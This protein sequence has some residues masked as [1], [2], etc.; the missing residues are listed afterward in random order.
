[1][2]RFF[3]LFFCIAV[4]GGHLSAQETS[5]A[6]VTSTFLPDAYY[7]AFNIHLPIYNGRIFSLYPPSITGHALFPETQWAT[8][9][10]LYDGLWYKAVGR[11]DQ[12]TDELVI[13][14][15][16]ST[17]TFI[18]NRSRISSFIIE[19]KTFVNLDT[20]ISK[21]TNGFYELIADGPFAVYSKHVVLLNEDISGPVV[22]KSFSKQRTFYVRKNG[23]FQQVR[24]KKTFNAL[25]KDK[26]REVLQAL[27]E[28]NLTFKKD[29]ETALRSAALI[30]K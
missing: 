16:D 21:Q 20:A 25:I 9:S 12:Y 18:L 2:K 30:Y 10:V 6:P 11:Y 26:K 29:P 1:M 13:R 7:D 4:S 23:L 24:T 27:R 17:F 19:G 5:V 8:V 28:D 15:P 3:P 22:E 14:N